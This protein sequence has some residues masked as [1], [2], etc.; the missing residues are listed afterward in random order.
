[1][2]VKGLY[3]QEPVVLCMVRLNE[4]QTVLECYRYGLIFLLTHVVAVNILL[5]AAGVLPPVNMFRHI[6]F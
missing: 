3:L 5:F 1:M 6:P 2:R 4:V